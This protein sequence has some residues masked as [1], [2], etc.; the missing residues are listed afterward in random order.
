M[1]AIYVDYTPYIFPVEPATRRGVAVQLVVLIDGPLDYF[2]DIGYL[3][4]EC[5]PEEEQGS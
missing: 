5:H 4:Q 1:R 2:K 3:I